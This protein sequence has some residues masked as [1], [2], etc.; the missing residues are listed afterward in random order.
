[1]YQNSV[2]ESETVNEPTNDVSK[3]DESG[4]AKDKEP[5]YVP[6]PPYK[7]YVPYPQRLVKSNNE[8]Q[9]KK[10]VE[11]LKQL[12]ITIQFTEATTQIPSYSK[13]LKET[14]SEKK[15]HEDDEIIMLI[16]ECSDIIQNNMAPKLKDLGSFSIPCVIRKFII[17]KALCNLG[18]SVS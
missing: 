14:L 1:M 15:K 11:L 17:D 2:K 5:P 3:E 7:P 10:F 9:L 12:N 4:E 8:G 13:F 18:A 16:V 6:P